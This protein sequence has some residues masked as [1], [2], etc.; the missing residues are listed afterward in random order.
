MAAAPVVH[1]PDPRETHFGELRM[2]TDGGENAEAYFS[3][4]SSRLIFQ[5]TRPPFECDQ[6]FTMNRDG[7]EQ[8]VVSTGTGRTTCAYFLPGDQRILYSSTHL[9][10]P[11]CPP[12]PDFSRG[13]VWPIDA[14]YDLFTAAPD[15]SDIV[16]LTETPGYDAEA[17]VSPLGDR[18][19]FTSMRDGDLDIYSMNIDG[20]D[21]I[22]LT[23]SLGYDG[24]PFFSPDGSKIVFRARHP[25]DPDEIADYSALLAGGLIRPSKLEVWVMDADGSNKRQITDLGVAAFAPFF[26]PS[27]SKIIFSSNYGDPTGREFE[28]FMVNLDGTGLEQIT[29]SEGFD[30]FPMFSPDGEKLVFCSN[31]HN[32]AEGETNVFV[33]TWKE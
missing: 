15:G 21:V 16:R 26:H 18:I 8:R 25:S 22:R 13:Y 11:E 1:Q 31:R 2:L 17:T 29:F 30:G 12:K 7:S 23:D 32:S 9:G 6:I 5:S 14:N 33:T 28:I 19:V 24:G 27:G 20:S 10:N 4:D 3:F